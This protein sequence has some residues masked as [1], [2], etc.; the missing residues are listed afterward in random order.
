M[1]FKIE[2]VYYISISGIVVL[3]FFALCAFLNLESLKIKKNENIH[4][5]I[6]LVVA[7]IV[8]F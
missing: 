7:A 2:F 3:L 6:N 8:I 1:G 4:S 5:G